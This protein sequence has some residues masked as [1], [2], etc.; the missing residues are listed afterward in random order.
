MKGGVL[1]IGSLFWQN[2]STNKPWDNERK[3]WRESHLKNEYFEVNAP[4]RYGRLSSNYGKYPVQYN[5]EYSTN[6]FVVDTNISIK[7]GNYFI[8][9]KTAVNSQFTMVLSMNLFQK[10]KFGTAYFCPF[11]KDF[12]ENKFEDE[13]FNEVLA[14]SKAEGIYSKINNVERVFTVDWGGMVSVIT[15]EENLLRNFWHSNLL[16]ELGNQKNI[17]EYCS[18]FCVINETS[19]VDNYGL[20]NK[21]MSFLFN[22]IFSDYD[23]I[24]CTPTRPR[25]SISNSKKNEVPKDYPNAER[26]GKK[27][28]VDTRRYFQNNIKNG[29]KTFEDVEIN[30]YI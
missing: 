8:E 17:D 22:E 1:I 19:V 26:I 28:Q 29:I 13:V 5:T 3:N 18:K 9:S 24:I 14:L 11:K 23:F 21:K 20:L 12:S 30:K 6:K 27:A 2:G 25:L 7:E 15:K 10:N 16:N 4:I